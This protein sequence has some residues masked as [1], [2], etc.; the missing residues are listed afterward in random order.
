MAL[1]RI[2]PRRR[3]NREEVGFEE[4]KSVVRYDRRDRIDNLRGIGE[5]PR[6]P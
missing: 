5:N 1:E 4:L 6:R 2:S 3:N